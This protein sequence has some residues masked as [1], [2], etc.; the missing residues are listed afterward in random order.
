MRGGGDAGRDGFRGG[1]VFEG[2]GCGRG[3][4]EDIEEA[5][6]EAGGI[7]DGVEEEQ[8]AAGIVVASEGKEGEA[9][10]GIAAEALGAADEPE[11]ELIFESAGVAE[12]LGVVALGVVD[13]VAGVDL[14]EFRQDLAGGVGEMG[15]GAA[16]DL[17]EVALA[18]GGAGLLA[19]EADE[20][21]LR[22]GAL[23]AA[24]FAFRLAEV[25][26]FFAEFHG[27]GRP[28]CWSLAGLLQIAIIV[29]QSAIESRGIGTGVLMRQ[30]GVVSD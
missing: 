8:A 11:V 18:K 20:L 23:E 4:A 3:G 14:E 24:E 2:A 5:V 6:D 30:K 21:L 13:E 28:G 16:L 29:S 17:G 19:E 27:A 12:E 22:E 10:L 1:W 15:A 9:E 25:S 26:E 7:D